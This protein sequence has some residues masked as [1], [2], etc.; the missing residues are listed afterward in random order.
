MYF[1]KN[2]RISNANI[3]KVTN[4]NEIYWKYFLSTSTI[5]IKCALE[6]SDKGVD[7]KKKSVE[8]TWVLNCI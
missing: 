5:R 8:S 1:N 6:D 7:F 2:S 3:F 4:V